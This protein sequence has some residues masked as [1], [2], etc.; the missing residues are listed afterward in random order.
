V[1]WDRETALRAGWEFFTAHWDDFCYPL[2]DDVLVIPDTGS[3]VLRYHH[4]K[5]FYFGDGDARP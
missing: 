5:M 3:W 2:S 1:S 4:E